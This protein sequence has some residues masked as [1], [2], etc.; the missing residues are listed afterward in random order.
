MKLL[1]DTHALLWWWAND[2][3]LSATTRAAI[4]D[5]ANAVWVSAA[6]AWEMATKYRIGKLPE[7]GPLLPRYEAQVLAEG[8]QHLPMNHAHSIRSGSYPQAHRDPFDRMLAAQA[9]IE[10]A[11]LVSLDPA[12]AAFGV[13]LLW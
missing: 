13:D 6:S 1:L 10:N 8:F 4:A 2:P 5:P 3:Q 11:K 12:F 9:E 7:A